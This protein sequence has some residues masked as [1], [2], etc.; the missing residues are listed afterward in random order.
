MCWATHLARFIVGHRWQNLVEKAPWL[1]QALYRLDHA[2]FNSLLWLIRLLPV[3]TA[4]ALGGRLGG[5]LGPRSRKNRS[6]V[7]NFSI[8]FPELDSHAHQRLAREAWSNSGRVFAEYV[9]LEQIREQTEPLRLEF[10][11]H[12]GI[13]TLRAP[14]NAAVFVAAH[15]ANW[16]L[17]AAAITLRGVPLSAVYSPPTN[18]LLD[19]LMQRW[20]RHIDC[21]LIPRDDSMRPLM[22]TLAAGTSIGIIMDRR[23]DSGHPVA[24]F[25][26]DKPTSLIAARLALKY[27]RPLVPVR[28]ERL[29]GARFRV[30]VHP[31]VERP[32]GAGDD[33]EQAAAMTASVHRLFEQWIREAPGQWFPSKRLWPREMYPRKNRPSKDEEQ[34]A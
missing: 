4:S 14:E 34:T 26:H 15:Q 10:V 25:G 8:A 9:H 11:D 21:G 27:D 33:V 20:R 5:L 3:D 1:E 18:P 29:E 16:E 24:L 32:E 19:E 2:F 23:V 31:A 7:E 6:M 22:K 12:F 30:T 13:D 28:V 17:T